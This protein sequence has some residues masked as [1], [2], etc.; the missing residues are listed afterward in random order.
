MEREAA[1]PGGT[2]GLGGT[3]QDLHRWLVDAAFSGVQVSAGGALVS[4]DARLG[5]ASPVRRRSAGT[6]SPPAP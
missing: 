1:R 3:V 5:S 4:F 6:V 2:M